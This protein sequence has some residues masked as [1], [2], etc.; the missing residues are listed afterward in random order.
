MKKFLIG[1][2]IVFVSLNLFAGADYNI[3]GAGARAAGLGGAFI[4]V[5][6]DATAISWNP[7]GLTQLYRPEIS[8]VT[9]FIAEDWEYKSSYW[10]AE[11]DKQSHFAFNFA[12]AAYPFMNGKL[13]AAIAYQQQLDWYS[14]WEDE[15][16]KSTG[17]ANSITS[18]L[19]FR[20]LP[21]ISIGFSTNVW[22]GNW[23][24]DDVWAYHPDEDDYDY[25]DRTITFSGLNFVFGLMVDFN[26][27]ETPVPLKFG[28]T[29]RTPFDLE[30]A[31]EADYED[32][33]DLEYTNTVD[34]PIMLGFGASFRIGDYFTLSTDYEI[35]AYADSKIHYEL[36]GTSDLSDS[37]DNLSQIRVGAEY[38]F[39]TDFAVIPLRTGFKTIPTLLANGNGP[40]NDWEFTDQTTGTG[41]SFG[42]GLI[43]DRIAIDATFEMTSYEEKWDDWPNIG[44]DESATSTKYNTTISTIFY[45]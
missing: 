24:H 3:T 10:D 19:A 45:F 33:E 39:V 17:G 5:A 7:A 21:I 28:A 44:E 25:V 9:K 37:R 42:T 38:L 27:L 41:F 36:G 29:M 23:I 8:I 40:S 31:V 20:L 43:F 16:D 11:S 15:D 2:L 30:V 12:S 6:D 32:F 4:A 13:V 14:D 1:F 22:L 34:M 18:G 26:N 35:R